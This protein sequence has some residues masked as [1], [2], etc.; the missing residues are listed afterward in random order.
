MKIISYYI[1]Y[2]FSYLYINLQVIVTMDGEQVDTVI[3]SEQIIALIRVLEAHF[4]EFSN[5]LCNKIDSMILRLDGHSVYDKHDN[6]KICSEKIKV[7]HVDSL[8][9]ICAKKICKNEMFLTFGMKPEQIL[10]MVKNGNIHNL[11][12]IYN[13]NFNDESSIKI[14]SDK[15]VYFIIFVKDYMKKIVNNTFAF[16]LSVPAFLINKVISN[17]F[18]KI[19]ELK[20]NVLLRIVS[21]SMFM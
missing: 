11:Y 8:K 21:N 18:I 13:F 7:Y 15:M 10:K 12:E 19:K 5:N 20:N 14:T 2:L 16:K 4:D 6:K 9:K 17:K 3:D 1:I